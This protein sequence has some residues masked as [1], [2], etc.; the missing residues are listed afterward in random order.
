MITIRDF[1]KALRVSWIRRYV[2]GLDDHWTDIVDLKLTIDKKDR[3]KILELG[4][5]HPRLANLAKAKLPCISSFITAYIHLNEC[6]YGNKHD[7]D[8]R[9]VN[10]PIFYNPA[11]CTQKKVR[12]GK[13]SKEDRKVILKGGDF[14]LKNLY[15]HN[16]TIKSLHKNSNFKTLDELNTD[17][18]CQ[19]NPL[20]YKGLKKV[21]TD[22]IDMEG[23][24]T[25]VFEREMTIPKTSTMTE[26]F[27][28]T[29][30]G[31]KI[32]RSVIKSNSKIKIDYMVE[33]WQTRF[34]TKKICQSE[35]QNCYRGF[36]TKAFPRNM[37]DFKARLILGKSQFGK[38]L[39]KWD[40][41]VSPFCIY[42]TKKGTPSDATMFHVLY[43]CPHVN[44]IHSF[45][46]RNLTLQKN[47]TPV[48]VL[49]TNIRCEHNI[50]NPK[51]KKLEPS[52]IET[53]C[54]TTVNLD[55]GTALDFVWLTEV[56]IIKSTT[57]NDEPLMPKDIFKKVVDEINIFIGNKPKCNIS[58]QLRKLL[59]NVPK[60]P[61]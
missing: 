26:L 61:T 59:E 48:N 7:P 15:G 44:S 22:F 2:N 17:H 55:I 31:S 42:C 20:H 38:S 11:M 16:M 57:D 21:I 13:N 3:P 24:K 30:K 6:F 39:S 36:Q 34:D 51:R 14:G 33:K 53:K 47:L 29:N 54:S 4:T 58:F 23:P 27:A 49:L 45:I 60:N 18:E 9:W 10:G 5:E 50:P 19:M 56:S 32:F 8:N 46:A 37:L 1:F 12:K 41:E 40:Q 28:K 43:E 25:V 52:N 35:A